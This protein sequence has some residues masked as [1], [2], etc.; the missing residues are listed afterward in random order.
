MQ[1]REETWK[2]EGGTANSDQ[3]TANSNQQTEV[4]ARRYDRETDQVRRE[5]G[6][7]RGKTLDFGRQ[8]KMA[9]KSRKR[10]DGAEKR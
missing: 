6:D 4:T 9:D 7:E 1:D 5:R 2:R 3:K 8:G 10:A